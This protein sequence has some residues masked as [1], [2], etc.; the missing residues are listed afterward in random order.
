[1]M[2]PWTQAF[3]SEKYLRYGGNDPWTKTMKKI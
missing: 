2:C 3:D 1:M